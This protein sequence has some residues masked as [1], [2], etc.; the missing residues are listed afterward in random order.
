MRLWFLF[1]LVLSGFAVNSARALE[2]VEVK[3]MPDGVDPADKEFLEKKQKDREEIVNKRKELEAGLSTKIKEL[4]QKRE[5]VAKKGNASVTLDD[6]TK[7]V[8]EP[9]SMEAA[10]GMEAGRRVRDEYEISPDDFTI[11]IHDRWSLNATDFKIDAP[12]YVT[13]DVRYGAAKTWFCIPFSITNTTSKKRRIAPLFTAVT[14][15]GVFNQS[16]SG[17]VPERHVADSTMRPLGASETI[18]DKELLG[19][20]VSPMEP[21]IKVGTFA[22][23]P[24]KAA[25]VLSPMSTFEPGQTRWGVAVWSQFTDEF[26]EL[27]VVVHGLCNSHR[28][29]EHMRRVL[30]MTFERN[31]DEFHVHRSELKYKDKRF[32]F[33]WAWDMDTTVPLPADAKDP[34]IKSAQIQTPA[35]ANKTV[36]AF[37][38][39][40]KNS[41]RFTQDLA[42]NAVHFALP[43]EV[44][45]GGQKVLVETKI[46]DDG[47]SSIYKTQHLKA[48]GKESPKDR[49]MFKPDVEGSKT[50]TQRRTIT[51]ESGKELPETWACFD[52]ADVDWSDARLQIESA[53]TEKFD[54]KAAAAQNWERIAKAVA[55]DN[56]DVLKKNPGFLYDPR[57]RLTDDEF[58]S[59]KD[60]IAKA[61]PGA[62]EAAKAKK[63]IAAYFDCTSGL[64]TGLY[65]ITR[66]YRKPG[67]VE[68]TWLNEWENWYKGFEAGNLGEGAK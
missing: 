51:L 32:D 45:V 62:V 34:Q 47:R 24:E 19:Q 17:F 28:Y 20:R 2:I 30:I 59:V 58:N 4:E 61:I 63:T 64:S 21:S 14:P 29:E 52:E 16:G 40:M 44:D 46:I 5:E 43:I 66:S 36:W 41:T 35:G 27:K 56:A 1:V 12:Q 48:I 42:I 39:L 13:A 68:E 31:D 49:F 8:T 26:T 38:F 3:E 65:R 7:D 11:D 37:P 23:D 50:Q 60:Q 67:V 22:F 33:I 15:K 53:L 10:L 25:Y 9:A 6:Q 55:P 18:A 54:K 57:R